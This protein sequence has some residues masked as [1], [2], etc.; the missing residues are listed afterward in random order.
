METSVQALQ[1]PSSCK[2][3]A[4]LLDPQDITPSL[5]PAHP[6]IAQV[7]SKSDYKKIPSFYLHLTE[8]DD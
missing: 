2:P 1:V 5:Q 7:N 3:T 6:L 8:L 4:T